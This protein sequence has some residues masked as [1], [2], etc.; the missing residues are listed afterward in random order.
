MTVW[1]LLGT[2]VYPE[3]INFVWEVSLTSKP[4]DIQEPSNNIVASEQF[5]PFYVVIKCM[6]PSYRLAIKQAALK[7]LQYTMYLNGRLRFSFSR[8][9]HSHITWWILLYNTHYPSDKAMWNAACSHWRLVLIWYQCF[10]F[11]HYSV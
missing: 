10:A 9:H 6:K 1:L 11:F 5:L 4:D 2:I 7:V 8:A 3:K